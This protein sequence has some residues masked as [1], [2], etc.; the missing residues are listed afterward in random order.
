M[1]EVCYGAKLL[2][3]GQEVEKSTKG[4]RWNSTVSFKGTA[5]MT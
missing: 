1:A 4:K 3:P 5:L 2:T